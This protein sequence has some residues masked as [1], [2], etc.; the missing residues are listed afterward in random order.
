MR[1]R[2]VLAYS[3]GLDTSIILRWLIEDQ[4]YDVVA[5]TADV[6]QG[7]EVE[8]AREKALATGAVEAI[9]EDLTNEFVADF[10]FPALRANALYEGYYLLGTSLARPVIAKGLV[11]AADRFGAVAISHGA[12][13]K[14]NDQVRFELSAFALKPDIGVI[15]PW[16]EWEFRGR[17]DLV[18]YAEEHGIPVPVT[19][20][21]PYST[22]ANLLHIS[23]EGGVL[24]DP[25]A[26][27]PPGMFSMTT[28]PEERTGSTRNG[29][30]RVRGGQP[31]VDR[32]RTSGPGRAPHPRQR[33]RRPPWGWSGRHR[34]EPVRRHEVARCVRD[35]RRN[36]SVPRP[37]GGRVVDTRSRGDAS[38]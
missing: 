15:A 30:H 31:G 7:D 16:R 11:E 35:A 25:W 19:A 29:R 23:Y 28:D 37:S 12:T 33:P 14:G 17:A 4:G 1:D 13:G 20:E 22:D 5:Y 32:R 9:A 38:S 10:V 3:G 2:V 24:E 27:P 6:G 34:R 21:K 26:G 36:D 8:E 18:A